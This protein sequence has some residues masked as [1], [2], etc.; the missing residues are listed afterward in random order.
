MQGG[1]D[2]DGFL[3]SPMMGL[4]RSMAAPPRRVAEESGAFWS[5]LRHIAVAACDAQN[6]SIL[7]IF[8]ERE[9]KRGFLK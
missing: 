1:S 3:E 9:R 7:F 4:W 5:M 6:M 8:L 2:L